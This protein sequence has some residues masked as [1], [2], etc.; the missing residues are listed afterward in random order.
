M[1]KFEEYSEKIGKTLGLEWE[2]IAVKFSD[3][4]DYRGEDRKIRVCEAFDVARRENVIINFSKANC[5]CPGGRHFTGLEA[6]SLVREFLFRISECSQFLSWKGL[7]AP[8]PG[9]QYH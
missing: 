4:P 5:V 7:L 3:S 2:H 9:F 1:S 8:D 6:L